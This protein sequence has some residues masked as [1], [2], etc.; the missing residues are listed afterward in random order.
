MILKTISKRIKFPKIDEKIKDIADWLE[1]ITS[2]AM[3]ISMR[4]VPCYV[5]AK[6]PAFRYHNR[7]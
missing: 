2:Y 4:R 5:M 6:N 1:K 7:K 3:S